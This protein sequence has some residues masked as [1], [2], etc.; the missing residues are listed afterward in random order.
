MI[1]RIYQ[2]FF[3]IFFFLFFQIIYLHNRS[4]NLSLSLKC[5]RLYPLISRNNKNMER[6]EKERDYSNSKTTIRK[7]GIEARERKILAWKRISVQRLVKF[8]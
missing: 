3:P 6:E 2:Y 7:S 4:E 1:V 5:I 8:H